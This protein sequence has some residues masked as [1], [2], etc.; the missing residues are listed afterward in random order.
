M[1]A[2]GGGRQNGSIIAPLTNPHPQ[3]NLPMTK[4]EKE[5]MQA[6]IDQLRS[7]ADDADSR[8][9]SYER[10]AS[11]LHAQ[12]DRLQKLLDEDKEA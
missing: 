6:E 9:E 5:E 11:Q 8:A 4:K 7:D 10:E 2:R 12:A 3:T 1:G